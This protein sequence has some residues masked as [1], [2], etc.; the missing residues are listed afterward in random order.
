MIAQ[1]GKHL[2][3][4]GQTLETRSL[5][6]CLCSGIT[7]AWSSK[8]SWLDIWNQMVPLILFLGIFCRWVTFAG[9]VEGIVDLWA[10]LVIQ[11]CDNVR[12]GDMLQ[13]F[14]FYQYE[15]LWV[16]WYQSPLRR[17]Q[18]HHRD[19]TVCIIGRLE[20]FNQKSFY[21]S[22]GGLITQVKTFDTK[23][24]LDVA[25]CK[26]IHLKQRRFIRHTVQVKNFK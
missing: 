13:F 18:V 20:A 2:E 6:R 3:G 7:T 16:I 12:C 25:S 19:I 22:I 10:D 1:L 23:R 4:I 9:M 8:L 26:L 15:G 17:H 14:A 5:W 24:H 21:T 11:W